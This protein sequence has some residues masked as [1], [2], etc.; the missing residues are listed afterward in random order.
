MIVTM[1]VVVAVMMMMVTV[2]AIV[3]MPAFHK[4]SALLYDIP[5]RFVAPNLE[6]TSDNSSKCD[7]PCSDHIWCYLDS[8]FKLIIWSYFTASPHWRLYT[9][10]LVQSPARVLFLEN[11]LQ[12]SLLDL[13][14]F[15]FHFS[16]K[17]SE[18]IILFTSRKRRKLCFFHFN[19][20]RKKSEN[21]FY[22]SLNLCHILL[23]FW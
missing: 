23:H 17:K 5:A 7:R 14:P 12:I 20:S 4:S 15:Q 8:C 19:F 13:R 16:K 9:F 22:L 6:K 11:F 21:K 2:M 10:V 3:M 1:V 18:R